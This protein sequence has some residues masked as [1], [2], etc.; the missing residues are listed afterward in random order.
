MQTKNSLITQLKE[1]ITEITVVQK[2]QGEKVKRNSEIDQLKDL[3]SQMT[4][5]MMTSRKSVDKALASPQS[6]Q[7]EVLSGEERLDSQSERTEADEDIDH[8]RPTRGKTGP[9]NH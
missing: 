4:A 3:I 7:I 9:I 8:T 6:D 5:Q 1:Q 2:K